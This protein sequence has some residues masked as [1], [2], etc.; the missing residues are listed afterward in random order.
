MYTGLQI[1]IVPI[2]NE[3]LKASPVPAAALWPV[4][5]APS[6]PNCQ[7]QV[8][9]IALGCS[10]VA[11]ID[12]A[13]PCTF[14]LVFHDKSAAANTTLLTGAA[15]AAGDMKAAGG[16][17]AKEVVTVWSGKQILDP[18]DSIYAPVTETTVTTAG[19]GYYFVV[20][21]RVREWNGE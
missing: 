1:A 11:V 12:A 18:G 4:F 8:E 6:F 2:D 3:S 10:G 7:F 17:V 19:D 13:D 21:Y 16:V 9:A 20:A 14:N 5:G 15:G